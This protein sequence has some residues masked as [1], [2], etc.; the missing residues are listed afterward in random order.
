MKIRKYL[1]A[2]ILSLAIPSAVMAAKGGRFIPEHFDVYGTVDG[3]YPAGGYIVVND[4]VYY[5]NS[6]TRVRGKEAKAA[7]VDSLTTGQR[8]GFFTQSAG[9]NSPAIFEIWVLPRSWQDR[10]S[11]KDD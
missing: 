11:D 3:L 4:S 6:A 7:N 5:I 9:A 8:V 2:V 10:H 1:F